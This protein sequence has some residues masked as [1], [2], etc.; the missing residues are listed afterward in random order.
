MYDNSDCH[1]SILVGAL[2][3]GVWVIIGVNELLFPEYRGWQVL[4]RGEAGKWVDL[5]KTYN[6]IATRKICQKSILKVTVGCKDILGVFQGYC[7]KSALFLNFFGG[8]DKVSL[9]MEHLKN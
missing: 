1:V 9:R 8:V 5:Q 4:V 3:T 2:S 6:H 7:R